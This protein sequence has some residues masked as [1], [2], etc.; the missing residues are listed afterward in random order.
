MTTKTMIEQM[1]AAWDELW[2]DEL[3]R[4]HSPSCCILATRVSIAVLAEHGVKAWALPTQTTLF[5]R[6]AVELVDAGVPMDRW[7][8]HA[9]S[10]HAGA[11]S[12]GSGY[13]GHL[14][15]AT[16]ESLIDLS[17]RQWHREGLIES[18]R[19]MV[20]PNELQGSTV[21]GRFDR[22]DGVTMFVLRSH[23]RSYRY[24]RDWTSNWQELVPKVLDRMGVLA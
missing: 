10:I 2:D 9:W 7:P 8:E 12:P 23:D 20:V 11:L 17:A 3:W 5:N 1:A 13:P 22:E 16:D 15:A 24:A 19:S 21:G 18:R 4:T 14:W 6:P